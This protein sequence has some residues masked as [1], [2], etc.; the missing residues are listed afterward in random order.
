MTRTLM[1]LTIFTFLLSCSSTQT[2]GNMTTN[3]PACNL[4]PDGYSFLDYG[5][6]REKECV[7]QTSPPAPFMGSD[8]LVPQPRM[9]PRK[10]R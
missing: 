5:A 9:V 3:Y 10:N 4:C 2:C 8:P 6:D 1:A 7:P